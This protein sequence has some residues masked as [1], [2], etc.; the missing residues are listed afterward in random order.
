MIPPTGPNMSTGSLRAEPDIY[1]RLRNQLPDEFTVIHSVPWLSSAGSAV[2]GRPVPTGEIDFLVLHPDLGLLAVEVKGGALGY[3]RS[4]FVY[5]RTG[6]RLDPVRQV[7][8]GTHGLEGWL[9][10]QDGLPVRIGYAVLLPDSAV[11]GRPLPPSLIDT[12]VSPPQAIVFDRDDLHT[13]GEKVKALMLYWQ[14]TLGTR[15]LGGERVEKLVDLICPEADYSPGWRTRIEYDQKVW[16]ELTPEQSSGLDAALRSPRSVVTGW[17][18][19]GKTLLAMSLARRLDREKQDTLF[20]VYNIPLADKLRGQ[21]SDSR[22]VQVL[23]FHRLCRQAARALGK[24][25]PKVEEKDAADIWFRTEAP[26]VLREAVRKG[27]LGEFDALILDEAQVF[28][29]E[30]LRTLVDWIGAGKIAAFCDETQVF[31]FEKKTAVTEIAEV[32]GA[33][34]TF[35]LTVNLR[36]PRAVFE[37]LQQVHTSAHQQHNPRPDEP[38]ALSEL[39]VHDPNGELSEVL[40]RLKSDDVPPEAVTVLY[41]KW[42]PPADVLPS[43]YPVTVESMARFRGLES[44]ITVIYAPDSI[45]DDPLFCAY[46]R[47]TTKCIVI[48]SAYQI[49]RQACGRFGDILL[50]SERAPA[51]RE[52]AAAGSTTGIINGLRLSTERVVFHYGRVDWC[53]DWGAWM[54]TPEAGREVAKPLWLNHLS[55]VTDRPIYCWD[56]RSRGRLLRSKGRLELTEGLDF[57]EMVLA[58]C[59]VCE[60]VTPHT[61]VLGSP[62]DCALCEGPISLPADEPLEVRGIVE[63]DKMLGTHGHS[64]ADKE[65]KL[66]QP[67]TVAAIGRWVALT[68]DQRAKLVGAI[69]NARGSVGYGV[70]LA[71]SGIDVVRAEPG[72][73]LVL[74]EMA[75]RYYSWSK[76][77]SERLP[78]NVWR[79]MVALALSRWKQRGHIERKD[80]G[81]FYRS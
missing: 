54:I 2:A 40:N 8:R 62:R 59:E 24:T 34:T 5:L 11:A 20:L 37:R 63:C 67:P 44:P 51:I 30:W 80:R 45:A 72:E 18:G 35:I 69:L 41:H 73:D 33:T 19:T 68:D 1:W 27:K 10:G 46:S 3:D 29:P 56:D 52:A 16:L 49:T 38:E 76:W 14:R 13:L 48:Y 25:V 65:K 36:S 64:P 70:A 17:P 15:P 42:R 4:E 74:A 60:R 53:R 79:D 9:K 55:L 28:E 6:E 31:E 66:R 71:L 43:D 32:I 61:L 12:T 39:A 47:A 57:K 23:H 7:R 77:M 22:H 81:R 58:A 21:L 50:D 75:K 78:F 26:L